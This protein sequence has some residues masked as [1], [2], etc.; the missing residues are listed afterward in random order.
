MNV[1]PLQKSWDFDTVEIL[2]ASRDAGIALAELNGLIYGIP[3]YELLLTPL[4]AREAVASSEI[5]NIRTTTLDILL[6]EVSNH[7]ITVSAQKETLAYKKALLEGYKNIRGKEFLATN[8][9]VKIQTI[10]EPNKP[11][12]RNQMGTVIAGGLG[13]VIHTPPQEES[14]IRD[15]LKNLDEF[16]NDTQDNI[17]PLIKCAIIHYQFETIHPFFDGNGRTGRILMILYL[18]LAG[19][20][21]FPVLYLSGYIL[22]QKN[23]YYKFLQEVR[24]TDNWDNWILFVLKGIEKQS[25]E[26]NIKVK[27]ISDLKNEWKILLKESYLKFYSPQILDYLFSHA[28][29]TQT[30]LSENLKVSRPTA[31]RYLDT[32]AQDRFLK[33][34]KEG[35][36]RLFFISEFVNILS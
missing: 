3:N 34:K 5:E 25:K 9:L 24:D 14:L 4:T 35:K 12:I 15:L 2:K 27:R 22:A 26:T 33:S 18:V 11:G 29:Y 21:R 10:L 1:K 17:D 19:K 8:D 20:L 36:E 23:D 6:A 32:L 30:H 16:V 13:N 7:K 28:F 31:A